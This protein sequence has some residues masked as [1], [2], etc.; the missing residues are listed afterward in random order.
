[1][2]IRCKKNQEKIAVGLLSF[3]PVEKKDIKLLQQTI[4]AY[5]SN[6]NWHLY[7]CKEADDIVGR[8][9]LRSAEELNVVVQHMSVNALY[10][11]MWIGNKMVDAINRQYGDEYDV[12]IDDL[13][14]KFFEKCSEKENTEAKDEQDE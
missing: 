6:P 11:N 9:R 3:M 13:T 2:L 5:H 1:M 4:Q 7:L 14:K 10:R 12:C 8:I